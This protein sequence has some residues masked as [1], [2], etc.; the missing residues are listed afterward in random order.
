[1]LGNQARDHLNQGP[2]YRNLLGSLAEAF[3]T[4]HPGI[5]LQFK[6]YLNISKQR[7]E[8]ERAWD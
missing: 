1:M 7:I 6:T 3:R 5:K 8:R 2:F 4:A